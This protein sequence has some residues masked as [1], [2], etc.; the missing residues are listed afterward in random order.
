[1]YVHV[2]SIYQAMHHYQ[3]YNKVSMHK[4]LENYIY[5]VNHDKHRWYKMLAPGCP[6][7]LAKMRIV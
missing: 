5:M 7:K 1:M 6:E 3:F 2:K 4:V